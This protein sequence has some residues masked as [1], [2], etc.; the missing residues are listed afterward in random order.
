LFSQAASL[1]PESRSARVHLAKLCEKMGMF[2]EAMEWWEAVAKLSS[3]ATRALA[4]VERI[5]RLKSQQ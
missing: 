2:K 4:E 1:D 3:D 5:K